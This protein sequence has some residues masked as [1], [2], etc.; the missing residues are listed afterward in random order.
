[1]LRNLDAAWL[2]Q[3]RDPVQEKRRPIPGGGGKQYRCG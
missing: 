2:L 3:S 1:M